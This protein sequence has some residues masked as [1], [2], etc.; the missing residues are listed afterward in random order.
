MEW[1]SLFF[2]DAW[3]SSTRNILLDLDRSG[4]SSKSKAILSHLVLI[5]DVRGRCDGQYNN[6]WE[7]VRRAIRGLPTHRFFP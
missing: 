6:K 4:K 5:E 1:I 3:R 2:V 7:I